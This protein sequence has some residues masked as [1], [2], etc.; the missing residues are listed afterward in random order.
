M[1]NLIPIAA[2]LP[3][4]QIN[5]AGPTPGWYTFCLIRESENSALA[6]FN[7]DA[8]KKPKCN[9]DAVTFAIKEDQL[10]KQVRESL[11]HYPIFC[12]NG[13]GPFP[14]NDNQHSSVSCLLEKIASQIDTSYIYKDQLI[15]NL[16]LQLIH[17]A[18]KHFVPAKAV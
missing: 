16:T 15:A 11:A 17:F 4:H 12:Q 10:P 18:I 2:Q 14:L 9:P 8:S 5:I 6:L 1:N 13:Y 7:P 3:N